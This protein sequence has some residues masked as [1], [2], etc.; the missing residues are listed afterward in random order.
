VVTK[1]D[2]IC[3]NE[4]ISKKKESFD[5]YNLESL[6]FKLELQS[7]PKRKQKL[8]DRSNKDDWQICKP[9]LV[10]NYRCELEPWNDELLD[11]AQ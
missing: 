5:E 11:Q 4:L 8:L 2:A 6:C 1:S 7:H 3:E 10:N 9:K